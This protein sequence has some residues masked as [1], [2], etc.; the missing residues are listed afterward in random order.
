MY[1]PKED[2]NAKQAKPDD[3]LVITDFISELDRP[4]IVAHIIKTLTGVNVSVSREVIREDSEIRTMPAKITFVIEQIVFN[5]KLPKDVVHNLLN[6]FMTIWGGRSKNEQFANARLD[7]RAA[8][9]EECLKRNIKYV[10]G[11]DFPYFG[12]LLYLHLAQG[13][14]GVK[15][16]LATWIKFFG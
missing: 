2:Q 3:F 12:E 10:I 1:R 14:D 7:D 6:C 4:E 9:T 13:L 8:L 11:Y 5:F 16:T 15:I